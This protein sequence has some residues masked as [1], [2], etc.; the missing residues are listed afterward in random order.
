MYALS[1]C[2][3]ERLKLAINLSFSCSLRL[4]ELL[5]LTW[6]CVDISP[7]AIEENRA[8]VFINKE[9]QRIRKESLNALDG[10]DVLLVFPTNHKKNSTVRILKT[11]KTES[12]VRKIFLPKSVANMLVD[13]KAEQD[14]MKEI[15]GDEYMDYNLVMASTFG[16]PLGDGAIRGPLKKLIEDYNLPPVVFHSFRHSS[17][18]YKLKLNGGDIKAVQGDSG[19]AQVNMV[20]DVYSHILDDD[21]RKNAELFEE[22]FYEKKNLNPERRALLNSLAGQFAFV[23]HQLAQLQ[24]VGIPVFDVFASYTAFHGSFGHSAGHFGDE[25]RVNRFR[26]E[27]FG[28]EGEVVYVVCLVHHIGHGLLGKVGNGVHGSNFHGFVDGF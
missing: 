19:H 10:K 22:A 24:A 17:V 27:V 21:R 20:T 13:W 1:V 9:S 4:G 8:Y 3:D 6:D 16:L 28:T 12:S 14:E 7:E 2:E 18:T 25:A 23:T 26:D 5:G 15:L 11:P